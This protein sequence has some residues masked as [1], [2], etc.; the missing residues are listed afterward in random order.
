[1]SKLYKEPKSVAGLY[2]GAAFLIVAVLTCVLF[3][4]FDPADY[5]ATRPARAVIALLLVPYALFTAVR[6]LR[7][8]WHG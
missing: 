3:A 7:K 6:W 2:A 4:I 1:V 8:A 5:F